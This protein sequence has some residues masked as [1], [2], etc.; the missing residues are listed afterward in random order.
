MDITHAPEDYDCPFCHRARGGANAFTRQDD[1]IYRDDDVIA[2]LSLDWFAS[3]PGHVLITPVAHIENVYAL[4]DEL[5]TPMQRAIGRVARAMK[6]AYACTGVSIN[7]NN[8]PDGNQDVWHYHVHVFP[9]FPG[10]RKGRQRFERTTAEQRAPYVA[11]LRDAIG[12]PA[13]DQER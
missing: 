4:P 1:L 12:W 9:R 13:T 6:V 5:G 3:T 7:Q 8:E 11:K 2:F 10:D